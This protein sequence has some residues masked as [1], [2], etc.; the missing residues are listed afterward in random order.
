[1]RDLLWITKR[2]PLGR[3]SPEPRVCAW[4]GKWISRPRGPLGQSLCMGY[5]LHPMG[6]CLM[7]RIFNL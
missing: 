4:L 5:H 1:M 6:F 7:I 3:Y 2:S